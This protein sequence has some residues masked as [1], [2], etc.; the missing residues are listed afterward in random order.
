MYCLSNAATRE[1]TQKEIV[2]LAKLI[3]IAKIYDRPS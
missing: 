2:W 1:F 3:K